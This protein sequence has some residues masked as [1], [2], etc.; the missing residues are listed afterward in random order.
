MGQQRGG[1]GGNLRE[2]V[3]EVL[4]R[5]RDIHDEV[6]KLARDGLAPEES[7]W[8]VVNPE[9]L[10]AA[11]ATVPEDAMSPVGDAKYVEVKVYDVEPHDAHAADR[12]EA[13]W[14][15]GVRVMTGKTGDMS[16]FRLTPGLVARVV[17]FVPPATVFV[18]E[19]KDA[20]FLATEVGDFSMSPGYVR[21]AHRRREE[22]GGRWLL[23][24]ASGSSGIPS[25]RKRPSVVGRASP[26]L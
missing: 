17:F 19:T 11:L 8:E 21:S 16:D 13:G 5:D 26:S 10:G 1:G 24:N 20:G 18:E 23:S 6:G 25:T 15:L 22:E 3:S 2:V 4:V 14:R 7:S 9:E 12:T